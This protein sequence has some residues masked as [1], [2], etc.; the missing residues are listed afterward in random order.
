M[1]RN[2][3]Y[4]MAAFAG[5]AS[6]IGFFHILSE[7]PQIGGHVLAARIISFVGPLGWLLIFLSGTLLILRFRGSR[8]GQILAISFLSV[9]IA[10][11]CTLMS[12]PV[13]SS[14]QF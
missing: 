12:A 10:I 6:G 11:G 3:I 5:A 4:W 9:A 1:I 2:I 14:G 7:F 8:P 13:T